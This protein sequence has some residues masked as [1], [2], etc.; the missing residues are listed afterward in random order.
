MK[1]KFLNTLIIVL[2]IILLYDLLNNSYLIKESIIISFD[3]WKNN[4]FP[5]LFPFFII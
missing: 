5:Y 3:L 2:L 1:K 4:I